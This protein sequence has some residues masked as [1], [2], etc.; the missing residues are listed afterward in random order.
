MKL[1][2]QPVLTL[3]ENT[4]GRDFVVGDIHGAFGLVIQAMHA[5]QFDPSADRLFAVGDL[6][7]RGPESHRVLEF[8]AQPY[9]Y[10]IRGNHEDEL[11]KLYEDGLPDDAVL[12]VAC[13]F[14]G[15]QWW[16]DVAHEKRIKILEALSKLP[17]AI[18]LQTPRGT[19]GFV[20]ADIPHGMSW[21]AFRRALLDGDQR[22][23]ETCLWGRSRIQA[24]DQTGVPG[25][26]RIFVGHTPDW[27]GVQRYGNVFAIDSAACFAQSGRIPEGHLSLV[28]V[29][30][31]TSSLTAPRLTPN[32][33]IEIKAWDPVPDIPFGASGLLSQAT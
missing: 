33:L 3:L 32:L 12:A 9:V 10:S 1:R 25:I 18:E 4:V 23:R 19:V 14:N 30:M 28:D 8:L 22:T 5:V 2:P 16:L 21:G 26:G 7:D 20:H 17:L 13:R 6:I 29:L 24:R 11:L 27:R 15:L 31:R